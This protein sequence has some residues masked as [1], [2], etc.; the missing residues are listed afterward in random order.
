MFSLLKIR[1]N[2]FWLAAIT[3]VLFITVFSVALPGRSGVLVFK[4]S[5]SWSWMVN[6]IHFVTSSIRGKDKIRHG[7]NTGALFA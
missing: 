5:N 7:M 6:R 2:L 4:I 3:L 1:W